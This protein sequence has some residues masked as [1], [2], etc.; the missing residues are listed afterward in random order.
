MMPKLE[1]ADDVRL[2]G[3]WQLEC[4][5]KRANR[6][7]DLD[8]RDAFDEELQLPLRPIV[9][10]WLHWLVSFRGQTRNREG[11]VGSPVNPSEPGAG[12]K[13]VWIDDSPSVHCPFAGLPVAHFARRRS[14]LHS[15]LARRLPSPG[16][17]DCRVFH[18]PMLRHLERTT[19]RRFPAGAE[20]GTLGRGAPSGR[21]GAGP[22]AIGDRPVRTILHGS[23]SG[24][25]G[26]G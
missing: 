1:V 16:R 10:Q 13:D 15:H 20:A 26:R 21:K 7:G 8:A 3:A 17:G 24:R 5:R 14:R 11:A 4:N 9:R 18:D 23:A 2:D 25:G 22:L 19:D 6:P 12:T